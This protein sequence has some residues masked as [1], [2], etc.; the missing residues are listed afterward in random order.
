MREVD[1]SGRNGNVVILN[2]LRTRSPDSLE[3]DPIV[4]IIGSSESLILR[5]YA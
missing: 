4:I 5:R 1:H 2:C 3:I